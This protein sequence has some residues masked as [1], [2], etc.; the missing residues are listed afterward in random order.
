M[1]DDLYEFQRQ[2]RRE[3]LRPFLYCTLPGLALVAFGTFTDRPVVGWIGWT[4]VLAAIVWAGINMWRSLRRLR[5]ARRR[6]DESFARLE[7]LYR[8]DGR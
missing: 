8:E 5:E 4:L 2:S 6:L 1:S 7:R 3:A